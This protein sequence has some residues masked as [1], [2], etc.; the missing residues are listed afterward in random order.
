MAVCDQRMITLTSSEDRIT[1]CIAV[2]AE[3]RNSTEGAML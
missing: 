1:Q 2:L 3:I